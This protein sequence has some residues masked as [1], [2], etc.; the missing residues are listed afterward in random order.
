MGHSRQYEEKQKQRRNTT[1]PKEDSGA[2]RKIEDY[3]LL[4]EFRHNL[5]F[6]DEHSTV[7]WDD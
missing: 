7:Q 6:F 4:Q 3:R 5:E 1:K 2:W